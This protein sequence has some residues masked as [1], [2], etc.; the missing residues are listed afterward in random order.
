MAKSPD[1]TKAI[2][3]RLGMNQGSKGIS[4]AV[5]RN[6]AGA[7]KVEEDQPGWGS[8]GDFCCCSA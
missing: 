1:L 4:A 8:K 6:R 7:P 2:Q 5:R 3:R